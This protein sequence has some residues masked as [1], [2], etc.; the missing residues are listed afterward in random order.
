MKSSYRMPGLCFVA[1]F[2]VCAVASATASAAAPEFFH[3]VELTS[4]TGG[5]LS[6][7]ALASKTKTG[8]F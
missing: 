1:V 2:V 5:Y 8:E 4:K 3:C 6:T 7:C